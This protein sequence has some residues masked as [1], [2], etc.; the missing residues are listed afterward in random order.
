M[1]HTLPRILAPKAVVFDF[2]RVLIDWDPR[3]LYSKVISDPAELNWFLANVVTLE[4]HFEHDRGR[5][6]ADGIAQLTARFPDHADL[7]KMWDE[8]W[9][10]TIGNEVEGMIA[11]LRELKARSVPLYG[12]TNFSAE[13]FDDFEKDYDWVSLFDDIV[14]SGREKL[15]KPDPA[16]FKLAMSRFGLARDE[17]VFVDDVP[18]NV[19]AASREGLLGHHFQGAEAL[20]VQLVDWRLL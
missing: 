2:G 5:T 10:D 1:A 3:Y 18:A 15:I 11:I 8:R 7:I 4:W 6:F 19:T 12:I 13:K 9:V 17:A 14:V 20:R 16:I